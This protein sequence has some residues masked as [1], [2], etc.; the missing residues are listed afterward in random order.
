MINF[1][2]IIN[3][4]PKLL[5]SMVV[6][7]KKEINTKYQV[8]FCIVGIIFYFQPYTA[9]VI[10]LKYIYSVSVIR[11]LALWL[12]VIF[13]CILQ[14][15]QPSYIRDRAIAIIWYILI[16]YCLPFISTFCLLMSSFDTFWQMNSIF[17]NL[18][19]SLLTSWYPFVL[20]NILGSMLGYLLYC[21]MSNRLALP[22]ILSAAELAMYYNYLLSIVICYMLIYTKEKHLLLIHKAKDKLVLINT[23]LQN[24]INRKIQYLKTSL[25][26]REEFINNI[27]H[28]MRSPMQ[29]I[30][31]VAT[32]LKDNWHN[33]PEESKLYYLQL[34]IRSSETLVSLFSN[35]LDLGKFC[36]SKMVMNFEMA[37]LQECIENVVYELEALSIANNI[38]IIFKRSAKIESLTKF[39]K[40]RIAQVMRNLLSNAIKYSKPG[41]GKVS[42]EIDYQIEKSKMLLVQVK[43]CGVGIPENELN[44]IF[45]PF[46]QSAKTK[47]MSGGTGLGLSICAEIVNLHQGRIWAI[48]NHGAGSSFFFTI[49]VDNQEPSLYNKK[50]IV[51]KLNSVGKVMILDDDPFA[52]EAGRIILS[53]LGLKVI[54]SSDVTEA[55]EALE[56]NEI[57]LLFLDMMLE[58]TSGLE[59]L[60]L[61]RSNPAYNHVRVVIASGMGNANKIQECLQSGALACLIKPYNKSQAW[62][63]INLVYKNL[64]DSAK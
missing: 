15:G 58:D 33:I 9:W 41:S 50:L 26:A 10:N 29:G 44:I 34:I 28:E 27:S 46:V 49:P 36:A 16:L 55:L 64:T 20:L 23:H 14:V 5:D 11:T 56:Q 22:T 21:Y 54:T 57:S 18:T 1:K 40:I 12:C 42:V 3:Q 39:D 24:R 38:P 63:V 2:N 4:L 17:C 61:L 7:Q 47:N 32:D 62:E 31:G 30:Y 48:N 60:Q 19:L 35:L 45:L 52:T 25:S 6:M 59:F 37:D 13:V 8:L 43:D 53:S 51:E